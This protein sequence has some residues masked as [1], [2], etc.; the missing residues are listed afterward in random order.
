MPNLIHPHLTPGREAWLRKLLN[1]PA[2][3]GRGPAGFQCMKLG[4]TEWD[5]RTPSGEQ[6]TASAAKER[7]GDRWF[8]IVTNDFLERI[9]PEGRRAL[10]K[11]QT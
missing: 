9:T 4:W 3:R 10:G 5:Y 11:E 7:Y 8:E 6:I 2:K 1:G